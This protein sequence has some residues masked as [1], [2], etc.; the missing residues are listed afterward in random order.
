MAFLTA[1]GFDLPVAHDS[2]RRAAPEEIGSDERMADGSLYSHRRAKK[3][4]L[5]FEL[6]WMHEAEKLEAYEGLLRGDGHVWSFDSSLYSS[7][8]LGPSPGYGASRVE[9]GGKFASYLDVSSS[10]QFLAALGSRWTLLLWKRAQ[11][12]STWERFAIRSDGAKWKD[13]TRN[14][15]LATAWAAVSGGA[16]TLYQHVQGLT[17]NT[18]AASTAYALGQYVQPTAPNG[19]FYECTTAG[20]SGT[21]EP[22]W[23]TSTGATITDGTVV[24]TDRGLKNG[25]YDDV[26]ALP[27]MVPT[28]W[29]PLVSTTRAFPPLPRLE[30]YG[31]ALLGTS[32]TAPV[33][34]KGDAEGAEV[35]R[36]KSGGASIVQRLSAVLREV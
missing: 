5:E 3:R 4:R 18:W 24:W 33:T 30:V 26:V 27:Y 16:L 10:I 11:D 20:T 7:K 29:P 14:D 22:A 13:G 32:S 34:M 12:G 35:Q 28:A 2:A 8:G 23:P 25:S 1:N 9:V 31:D 19:R 6:V 21:G 15:A 36:G 17:I